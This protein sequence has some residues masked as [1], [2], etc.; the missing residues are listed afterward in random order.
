MRREQQQL[1]QQ[2]AA[3]SP[4]AIAAFSGETKRTETVFGTKETK[5][6]HDCHCIVC[7]C[8]RTAQVAL[9]MHRTQK[10]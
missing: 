10:R 8:P 4:S 3:A 9:L 7:F 2:A 6:A 5:F 1:E